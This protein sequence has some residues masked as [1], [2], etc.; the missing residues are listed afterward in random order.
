[1]LRS[2]AVLVTGALL[3]WFV[4]AFLVF[5]NVVM[6]RE[7]FFQDGS[8]STRAFSRLWSSDRA[9]ASMLNSFLLAG[10]LSVTVNAVG[11]FIVLATRYFALRGARL[12]WLGYATT[13]VYGGVVAVSG[14][15]FVYGEHGFVT[16]LMRGVLSGTDPA[17]FSGMPAVVMVMT[18]TGTSYHLLFLTSALGRVDHQTIEAAQQLGASPWRI[19]RTVVLPVLKPTLFAVTVLT[20]LGGLTAF[21]APQVLGGR[22]FQTITPMILTFAGI[23]TSR[24]LAATLAVVLGVATLILLTVLNRMQAGGTYFSVSKVPS[25]LRRQRIASPVANAVVHVLTYALFAAYLI[26]PLLIVVFSFTDASTIS[27]GRITPGSFTLANYRQVLTDATA[28]W[29]L[30]VS[31]GYA[32]VTAAVVIALMLFAARVLQKYVN[33][34]TVAVEYLLHIPWMLPSTLTALGLIIT[35]SVPRAVVGGRVLTGTL[36][37]LAVAYIAAKIPITL[38][39]LKAAYAGI[40]DS[41]EEAATLL[42]AG[43]L[44]TFRRVLLPLVLPTA[45]AVSALNFNS[46]LDDYDIS[47]FL[48]HPLYQP[49]GIAIQNATRNEGTSDST[50]LTLVYAVVLMVVSGLVM[51]FVYGRRTGNGHQPQR[52]R[53]RADQAAPDAGSAA[54]VLAGP[55]PTA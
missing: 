32:A 4:L 2:P 40:P 43:G 23:P 19:L 33:P 17:W 49:L 26:P 21:A 38:R 16:R 20:F 18:L 51:W 8:F 37:L 30:L 1:M 25:A 5:P 55:T 34:V 47:V 10:V 52:A 14:Y 31:I 11:V 29:P 39:M 48:A 7:I 44:H 36:V 15:A 13:L 50:A 45:A 22:D 35:Y 53:K 42:G 24:D 12:L 46:L 3:L 41:L 9:R 27:S 54:A 28:S 6:L